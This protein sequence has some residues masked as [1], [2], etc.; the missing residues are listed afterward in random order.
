VQAG[1][2]ALTAYLVDMAE[3]LLFDE[4]EKNELT[5]GDFVKDD[6]DDDTQDVGD[7]QEG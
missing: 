2:C 3:D 5:C 6:E 1:S 7:G 4:E